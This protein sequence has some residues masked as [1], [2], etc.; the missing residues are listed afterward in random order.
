[1]HLALCAVTGLEV[2]PSEGSWRWFLPFLA[3]F[4]FSILLL[5][6]LKIA[7]PLLVFG[8]LGTLWWYL[9][10]RLAVYCV[11]RLLQSRRGAQ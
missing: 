1:M 6:L 3:D 8:V 10:N 4:P 7:P 11:E 2:F 5:P 9:I